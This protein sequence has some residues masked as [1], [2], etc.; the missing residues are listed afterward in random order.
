MTKATA[1]PLKKHG[2]TRRETC[3]CSPSPVPPGA[4]IRHCDQERGWLEPDLYNCTSPPFVELNIPVCTPYHCT[5]PQR[6]PHVHLGALTH[7][8]APMSSV[9]A[10]LALAPT[11]YSDN[12]ANTTDS[13]MI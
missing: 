5:A 1:V 13:I 6:A 11:T 7:P 8:D 2:P 3:V 12:T 10:W 4:A 9:V